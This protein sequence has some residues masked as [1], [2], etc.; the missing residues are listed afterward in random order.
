MPSSVTVLAYCECGMHVR[1]KRCHE[2]E[3]VFFDP[4]GSKNSK[5]H[6]N[7]KESEGPSKNDV[8]QE[9]GGGGGKKL[10][11]YYRWAGRLRFFSIDLPHSIIWLAQKIKQSIGRLLQWNYLMLAEYSSSSFFVHETA[12]LGT[13]R[14]QFIFKSWGELYQ[15]LSTLYRSIGWLIAWFRALT[16]VRTVLFDFFFFP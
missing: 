13:S 10:T 7:V 3:V 9:A 1:E 5:R 11:P 4:T 6:L 16:F 12:E 15:P 8:S 2:F 14:S